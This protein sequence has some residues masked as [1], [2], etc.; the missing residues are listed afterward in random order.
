[1]LKLDTCHYTEV[2]EEAQIAGKQYWPF[3]ADGVHVV[4]SLK[5][6]LWSL[7]KL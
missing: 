5:Q 3:N 4:N 1:M 7:G 2:E 6:H